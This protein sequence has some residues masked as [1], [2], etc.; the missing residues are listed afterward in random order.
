MVRYGVAQAIIHNDEE[1]KAY[2][3]ATSLARLDASW[4]EGLVRF[5][6]NPIVR[7]V[8]IVIFLLAM[9]IEMTHPGVVLP[10]A[11]AGLALIALVVPPILIDLAAWWGVAAVLAGIVC[12]AVEIFLIPGFGVFGILGIVLL[13]GGLIGVFVGGPTGLFPT[14]P[15]ARNDLAYGALTVLVSVMTS[16]ILMYFVGKHLPGLPVFNR[17]VLKGVSGH[18]E[19]TEGL[20]AAMGDGPDGA[21]R[22]GVTGRTLTPLRPA[23][24]IQ[25]GRQIVDVVSD[26]GFID[27]DVDVR[28]TAVEKFRTV[29]EKV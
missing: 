21:I 16:M 1:L 17:L 27:A 10:G 13:F 15:R 22:P 8:L 14:S 7:G 4:S 29:V 20:L 26:M 3:G 25:V 28:I 12:V 11:I 5:L 19:P 6:T 24:R 9:F 23:G 2:F 18:E